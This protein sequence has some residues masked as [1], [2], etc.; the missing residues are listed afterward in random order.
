MPSLAREFGHAKQF[1]IV[2]TVDQDT[3]HQA[4]RDSA[5]NGFEIDEY[6]KITGTFNLVCYLMVSTDD[7]LGWKNG[8]KNNKKKAYKGKHEKKMMIERGE[9]PDAEEEEEEEER[10]PEKE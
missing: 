6:G 1:D 7:S 5:S 4:N 9:D 8:I 2:V 10:L 3:F